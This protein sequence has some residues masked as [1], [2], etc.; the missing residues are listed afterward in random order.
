MA[1]RDA[2]KARAESAE[3]FAAKAEAERDRM[4]DAINKAA[5]PIAGALAYVVHAVTCDAYEQH[6]A[7]TCGMNDALRRANAA[8]DALAA[9]EA[10]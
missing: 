8:L 5:A 1:D 9:L 6:V 7:C 4:R 10:K 3:A 2:W